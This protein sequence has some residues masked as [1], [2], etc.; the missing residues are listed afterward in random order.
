MQ[1]DQP[2]SKA[3]IEVISGRNSTNVIPLTESIEGTLQVRIPLIERQTYRVRL[4]SLQTGFEN[5]FS[6]QYEIR[7]I[8]DLPPL[9]QISAPEQ[10]V[11]AAPDEWIMI[12]GKV[13]DNL[14][15][16]GVSQ[17][18]R[19]NSES[20][21]EIIIPSI[22][23]TNVLI[24]TRWD[25]I[26]FNLTAGDHVQT[27]FSALDLKG[28][29]TESPPIDVTI[30]SAT[31]DGKRM[32]ALRE[33]RR[34]MSILNQLQSP[35]ESL[36][37][38]FAETAQSLR[39]DDLGLQAR[40]MAIKLA[41]QASG[42]D[43]RLGEGLD[44]V[45]EALPNSRVGAESAALYGIGNALIA[46]R[47]YGL[48]PLDR[49]LRNTEQTSESMLN[50]GAQ[51]LRESCSKWDGYREVL[52]KEEIG[53]VVE[54]LSSLI[55]EQQHLLV[56]SAKNQPEWND[57]LKRKEIAATRSLMLIEQ[58]IA[59]AS[60]T[61]SNSFA[62]SLRSLN[63]RIT[64]ERMVF[65]GKLHES[66]LV[67]TNQILAYHTALER[68]LGDSL[69][70]SRA[71]S[72]NAASVAVKTLEVRRLTPNRPPEICAR[73]TDGFADLEGLRPDGNLLCTAEWGNLA[74]TLRSRIPPG[75]KN[76][77]LADLAPSWMD[78]F[79]RVRL[80]QNLNELIRN[81]E[82][83]AQAEQW[84]SP[85]IRDRTE[86]PWNWEWSKGV[87]Q[88]MKFESNSTSR[89]FSKL[90]EGDKL[91]SAVGR[92]QVEMDRRFDFGRPSESVA[93]ELNIVLTAL[94]Q[95]RSQAS[96][97]QTM[98]RAEF[99]NETPDLGIRLQRLAEHSEDFRNSLR[100]P[101]GNKISEEELNHKFEEIQEDLRREIDRVCA[102]IRRT[103]N[104]QDL[105]T[106]SGSDQ[107]RDADDAIAWLSQPA[108]LA[109][110]ALHEA[111][112]ARSANDRARNLEFAAAQHDKLARALLR[113]DEHFRS[114]REGNPET[115]RSGLRQDEEELGIKSELDRSYSK[116]DLFIQ[117]GQSPESLMDGLERE[118][119]NNFSMRQQIRLISK[120]ILSA[121]GN[122]VLEAVSAQASIV[123]ELNDLET[124]LASE[125]QELSKKAAVCSD[126][127]MQI[128]ASDLL[129]LSQDAKSQHVSL[130][131]ET[132]RA[133]NSLREVSAQIKIGVGQPPAECALK[134]EVAA[135]TIAAAFDQLGAGAKELAVASAVARLSEQEWL[136]RAEEAQSALEDSKAR[137]KAAVLEIQRIQARQEVFN[138]E[139]L[140][141]QF[142]DAEAARAIAQ[143]QTKTAEAEAETTA[144]QAK[145]SREATLRIEKMDQ[146]LR[147]VTGMGNRTMGEIRN[148]GEAFLKLAQDTAMKLSKCA[149]AEQ[150]ILSQLGEAALHLS[151]A[152][153]HAGRLA[154]RSSLDE[155][156]QAPDCSEKIKGVAD[157]THRLVSQDIPALQQ[158]IQHAASPGISER[159]AK[160]IE[161]HLRDAAI[162]LSEISA[163]LVLPEIP[164]FTAESG[165]EQRSETE[166]K[167]LART[168]DR[169]AAS[170]QGS[171]LSQEAAAEF[172]SA[173][174]MAIRCNQA[175][176]ALS[177]A[178][179]ANSRR[180][181]ES[182]FDGQTLSNRKTGRNPIFPP[183]VNPFAGDWRTL[184]HKIAEDLFEGSRDPV[185]PEY[186][187]MVESY[188]KAIAEKARHETP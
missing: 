146:D 142:E 75:S 132:D 87:L 106:R 81:L 147:K 136:A 145:I 17:W 22:N 143:T 91:N 129:Q 12:Q 153:Q 70:I 39:A 92:I 42:L 133:A 53:L 182:I 170:R 8:P 50:T 54:S 151:R 43:F 51:A 66:A 112:S 105:A 126:K 16:A 28:G 108:S 130:S 86:T 174:R 7:P 181:A 186:Q 5:K 47:E 173:L 139:E 97:N 157:S 32:R 178:V 128:A 67:T 134:L 64:A 52:L 94:Q 165:S 68:A 89:D 98:A 74:L 93:L 155:K 13:T 2:V 156:Q 188:F 123:R 34:I 172:E 55:G 148:L 57:Q 115:T 177:R 120:R 118:L 35:V 60:N 166:S 175:S 99:M 107:A 71:L 78:D 37:S 45:K 38:S 77:S 154:T 100:Q 40:Q 180:E 24:Q 14:P 84:E 159:G 46:A 27:K 185:S 26:D 83:L 19:K 176:M 65:Q 137:V 125:R 63:E 183:E 95:F 162:H 49:A 124:R 169:L 102:I 113:L 127:I 138:T 114:V 141:H 171:E 109:G 58:V 111:I 56:Q 164:R 90:L 82:N 30:I 73:I 184:P 96:T 131:A 158:S 119:A 62:N 33:H 160:Q 104:L 163:L 10:D 168:L 152:A 11:A 110:A 103:A 20:W 18:V 85:G 76:D 144:I 88:G 117:R 31:L 149:V 72:P 41:S 59:N 23:K 150:P 61:I 116:A 121:S 4:I 79:E 25:L 140:Q 29:R 167:W 3:E 135:K 80:I 1:L 36:A 48:S 21:K 187:P 69:A 9:L 179:A 15:L 161:E 101:A 122:S 44:L 6:P